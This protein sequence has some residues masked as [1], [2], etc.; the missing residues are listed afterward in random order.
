MNEIVLL[1]IITANMTY[2]V[3][4]TII[5]ANEYELYC[6]VDYHNC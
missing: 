5:T 2:I 1:T 6:F 3:L 4:L